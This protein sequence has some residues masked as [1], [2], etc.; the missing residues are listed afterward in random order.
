MIA[1][2]VASSVLQRQVKFVR[3]VPEA[4]AA[5][6][7]GQVY[8]QVQDEMRL[9]IPP[10]LLHSPAP[11]VLAAYWTLMRETLIAEGRT[12]RATREVVAAA[13]SV[14]TICPYCAD[15]HIVGLYDLLGEDVAELVAEDRADELADPRLRAVARWARSAHERPAPAPLP[16]GLDSAQRA[17]LLGVAVTFHYLSRMVNVFLGN[18]LLPPGLGPN[19]RRRLKRGL[20]RVM[21]P[22]LRATRAPGRSLDLLPPAAHP[23]D[24]WAAGNPYVAAALARAVQVFEDAGRRALSPAVRRLVLARLDTWG[25]EDTGLSTRWCEELIAGLG[26]AD[27]AAARLALRTAFASYQVDAEVVTEFRRHQPGDRALIDVTAW[28][29]FTTAR[30]IGA[31]NAAANGG[32]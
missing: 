32:S 19:S 14:A 26:P 12:D 18:F 5:G 28:A 30:L 2:R 3:P 25:G 27:R 13:V 11:D 10:A 20:S 6:R 31:R 23:A 8:A 21:R 22:A 16:A 17:E 24:G 29:A 4:T 15:M 9:V 1:G 7:V